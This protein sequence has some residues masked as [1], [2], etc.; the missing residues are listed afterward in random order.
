MQPTWHQLLCIKIYRKRSVPGCVN[1]KCDDNGLCIEKGCEGDDCKDRVCISDDCTPAGCTG[2]DCADGHCSGSDCLG[3]GCIGPDC[4][5][6]GSD[7]CFGLRCVSWGPTAPRS[8]FTCTGPLCRIVT[9]SGRDCANGICTGQ[10]CR[11]EDKDCEAEEADSCTDW[12]SSTLVTPTST[13][14]ATTITTRCDRPTACSAEA[15][16]TTST[17]NEDGLIEGTITGFQWATTTDD[18]D[19][20]SYLESDYSAFWSA[21]DSASTTTTATTT[22]TAK[23]STTTSSRPTE[24]SY[25]C[26]GS[27]RCGSFANLHSFCNMAMDF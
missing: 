2:D 17:V 26:K 27:V 10:D 7:K 18:A 25:D 22:T 24:T 23:T 15:T 21:F 6:S 8:I 20:T 19:L 16:T 4:D 3:H 14:S 13:Y 5:S 12:M 1:E 11:S 9:C